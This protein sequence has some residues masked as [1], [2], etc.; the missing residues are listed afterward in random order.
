MIT[1]NMKVAKK[2]K[3]VFETK[4]KPK[5]NNANVGTILQVKCGFAYNKWLAMSMRKACLQPKK[6]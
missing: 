5:K 6:N 3:S 4:I 1:K 2:M